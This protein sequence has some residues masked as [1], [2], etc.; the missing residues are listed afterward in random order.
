MTCTPA[1]S[2]PADVRAATRAIPEVVRL[3]VHAVRGR[4]NLD[5]V[6][7]R[8]LDRRDLGRGQPDEVSEDAADDGGVSDDEQ[9]FAL[10][11]EL[12]ERRLQTDCE[13]GC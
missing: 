12:D 5:E 2:A 4:H 6:P 7:T 11:F 13:W 3:R 9:V 8:D 10:A 1:S